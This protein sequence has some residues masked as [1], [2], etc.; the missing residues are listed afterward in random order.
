MPDDTPE[1]RRAR[2]V[3]EL[4]RLCRDV[5]G[6]DDRRA[7]PAHLAAMTLEQLVAICCEAME[8]NA[9]R[10]GESHPQEMAEFR[11]LSLAEKI[12][13]LTAGHLT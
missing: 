10:W 12:N 3:E 6:A 7:D 9:R 8:E 13:L 11:A 1:A 4:P 5:W 2:F